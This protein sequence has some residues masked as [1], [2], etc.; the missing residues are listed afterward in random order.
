MVIMFVGGVVL[1]LDEIR[2]EIKSSNVCYSV[3]I[4]F[5]YSSY[6]GLCRKVVL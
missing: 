3:K 2:Y 4:I 6:V 1:V 5:L